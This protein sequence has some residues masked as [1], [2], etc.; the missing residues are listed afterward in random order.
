MEDHHYTLNR[1]E[2]W[3][4]RYSSLKGAA[5]GWTDYENRKVLIHRGLKGRK[6]LEIELHEGLHLTLGPAISEE[7][8]TQA[9]KDLAKIL[10]SLGYRLL[11]PGQL[12]G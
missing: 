12:S 9:A 11:P 2:K 4:W 8:V 7:S 5:D 6:R 1:G 3:L 10:H